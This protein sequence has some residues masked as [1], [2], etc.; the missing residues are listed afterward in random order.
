MYKNASPYGVYCADHGL[1][2]IL[3]E[4]YESDNTICPAT[5][6]N[7]KG[8]FDLELYKAAMID[9]CAFCGRAP[10]ITG[11]KKSFW[12]DEKH[13]IV[14][15]HEACYR[16]FTRRCSVKGCA[17]QARWIPYIVLAESKEE[18]IIPSCF[19][20]THSDR[21]PRFP[22]DALWDFVKTAL[23]TAGQPIPERRT[24]FIELRAYKL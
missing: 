12:Y 23:K 19:C 14:F 6:C 10:I 15:C 22:N 16:A 5:M 4:Q 17:A 11:N 21:M 24:C 20:H 13:G 1:Q 9:G 8:E 7:T 18:Y 3:K 2:F